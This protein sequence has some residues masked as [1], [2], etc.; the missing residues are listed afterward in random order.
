MN[1]Q[2]QREEA[3]FNEALRL[4]P[5]EQAAFLERAC[6]G[7]EPLRRRVEALLRSHEDSSGVLDRTIRHGPTSSAPEGS[8]KV[9]D[10][11]GR[12]KLLQ[13]I[14]E[15]GCGVVYMAEQV[16]PLRRRVALKIIKLG[17]DTEQV[18]TRFEAERQALAMME[19]PNIAKVFDAGSTPTGRPYFA[20]ELVSG[21]RITDYC[22]TATFSTVQRLKLFIQVCHAVQHAHQKGIIHR[23]IKPSNI[24]VTLH[25]GEPTPKVIDFGIAKA[26]SGQRLTD[27]TFFTAFDQFLGTPAYMS[28]EQA[29]LTSQDIDTRSDIYS[30]GVLLYEL[31]TGKTP[32][33][34]RELLQKG[35]E[36]MLRTIREDEPARPSTRLKAMA[37]DELTTTAARRQTEAPR[38]LQQVSGDL[39]WIVMKCLEKNP[40]GRY[41]T[42]NGLVMELQRYLNCEPV[43][44][45][46]PTGAYR[47]QKLVRRHRFTFT[48]IGAVFLAL[49]LGLA[50]ATVQ[51]VQQ[52]K[53]RE[54][55]DIEAKKSRAVA[56]FLEFILQGV[57]PSDAQGR[58][59][60]LLRDIMQKTVLKA[61]TE[62][63]NQPEVEAELYFTI[64][65]VYWELGDYTRAE[66]LQRRAVE[67][68]EKV[69]GRNSLRVA[70]PLADL[71]LTLQW[72]NKLAEAERVQRESLAIRQQLLGKRNAEVARALGDLAIVL[73]AQDKLT[74]SE[75]VQREALKIRR[76]LL[77]NVH[78]DV[79]IGLHNL[80]ALLMR[81]GKFDEAESMQREAL[82]IHQQLPDDDP[83]RLADVLNNLG[84]NLSSRGKLAEAEQVQREAL[85]IYLKLL[86]EQHPDVATCLNN[87]GNI[88]RMRGNL[89]EAEAV[90]RRALQIRTNAFGPENLAV[91]ISITELARVLVGQG[92]VK[93]AE[94]LHRQALEMRRKLAGP[95]H[96]LV[97]LSLEFLARLLLAEGRA[98]EAEPPARE[99]VVLR[100]NELPED[101]LAFNAKSLLGGVLLALNRP[102]EA[103]PALREGY[104]G[105]KQREGLIPRSGSLRCEEALAWLVRFYESAGKSD[106]AAR[107]RR[108][109][110]A[111]A[112]ARLRKTVERLRQ[113]AQDGNATNLN[114]AAWMFATCPTGAFRDG[115]L[116]VNL[117]EQAVAKTRRT[118]AVFLATLAAADAEAAEFDKAISVQKEAI[119]SADERARSELETR[120]GFYEN[121]VAWRDFESVGFAFV[122]Q[123]LFP[124]AEA[125]YRNAL[126]YARTNCPNA[127]S[128]WAGPARQLAQILQ[129]QGKAAEAD[130]SSD[131][132]T[133][134]PQ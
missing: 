116:A 5:P 132:K 86:G 16:E 23:D 122:D 20:M 15:G 134:R 48:A 71:G 98:A 39:D 85:A 87:V 105:M 96:P 91:A 100:Q 102:S 69:H 95:T 113:S 129:M 29:Q 123:G 127:P 73:Y 18:I 90:H 35:M 57:G 75:G 36:A 106:Q 79:A 27:Q 103:E 115:K 22:D 114:E 124:D 121:H 119:A 112:N 108:E 130:A 88:A 111:A 37:K 67:L 30:L 8:E 93:Q 53:A 56:D 42:A 64:G 12:Y 104:A 2:Y 77:G 31:L 125:V 110:D 128:L 118:N 25:D 89:A 19:H 43:L 70:G 65:K 14:G 11:I 46:R 41:A 82:A 120:L 28:P 84:S 76:E 62:L 68:Q 131:A 24:L 33:E 117:A 97:A 38:L 66:P 94:Q 59:T 83:R 52:R 78:A 49:L 7:D 10:R 126:A 47:L 1:E 133:R 40:A 4:P 74:E 92:D 50:I 21:A 17:M 80:A 58:D 61:R 6:A 54:R 63:T 55:A 109:L 101:W 26:T 44:A 34:T 45:R 72:E 13:R 9:G 81:E 60:S 32:F 99:C 51:Y 107:W 3:L